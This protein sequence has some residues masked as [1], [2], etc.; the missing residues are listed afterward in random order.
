MPRRIEE[1]PRIYAGRPHILQWRPGRGSKPGPGITADR[2]M[3]HPG[4]AQAPT[5]AA[6]GNG[7]QRCR[8]DPTGGP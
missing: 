1:V 2:I 3:N 6:Y 8:A 4:Q 7:K 5:A